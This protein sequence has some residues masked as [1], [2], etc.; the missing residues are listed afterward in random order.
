MKLQN[1]HK[2]GSF[3]SEKRT[4]KLYV[5]S[6]GVTIIRLYLFMEMQRQDITLVKSVKTREFIIMNL[7]GD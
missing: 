7:Y 1:H 6:V 4:E 5:Q 2:Q 3:L